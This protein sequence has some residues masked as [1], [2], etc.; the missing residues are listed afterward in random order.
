MDTDKIRHI[1]NILFLI[2]T[3]ITLIVY[4]ASGDDKELFFY[5]CGTTLFIKVMELF[6][7]FTR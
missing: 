4:F 1:L 3:L 5:T 7:R 2:G 6:M